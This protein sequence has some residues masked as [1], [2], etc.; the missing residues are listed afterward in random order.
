MLVQYLEGDHKQGILIQQPIKHTW[1]DILSSLFY[2]WETEVLRDT[3]ATVIKQD[4]DA[5]KD[6]GQEEKGGTEDEMVR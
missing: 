5:G 4:P 6:W 2:R 1:K 3:T